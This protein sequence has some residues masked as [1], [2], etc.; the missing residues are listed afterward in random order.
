MVIRIQTKRPVFKPSPY[1][2]SRHAR[3]LP[4]WFILLMIGI[5]I[6]SGGL[7]LLQHSYGPKQLSI[8]D[9]QKMMT[10]LNTLNQ[11]KQR[12]LSEAD[13]TKRTLETE[14]TESTRVRESL[15]TELKSVQEQLAP[16]KAQLGLLVQTL[17]YDP[18]HGPLGISTGSFTQARASDKL[19]YTVLLMQDKPDRPEFSGFLELAVEGNHINGR[20]ETI[21]KAPISIKLAHYLPLSGLIDLPEGFV[22]RRV[23]VK[24]LDA[25]GKKPVTWRL[26]MVQQK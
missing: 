26:M 2:T 5:L 20:N 7:L 23:N 8:A 14:R 11:D 25:S 10:E 15:E 1:E 3:R 18:R 16:M 9:S 22:A 12:L 4:S 19:S 6:G 13:E 24:V 17:P 21:T